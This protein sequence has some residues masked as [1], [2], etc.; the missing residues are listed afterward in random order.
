MKTN[1]T[2]AAKLSEQLTVANEELARLRANERR[3]ARSTPGATSG[4][5]TRATRKL[6]PDDRARIAD[7]INCARNI[8]RW[9]RRRKRLENTRWQHGDPGSELRRLTRLTRRARGQQNTAA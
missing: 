9:S 4:T 7:A 2:D 1:L 6:A 8:F 5:W 3:T